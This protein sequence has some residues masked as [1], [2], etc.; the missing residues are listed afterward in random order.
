MQILRIHW[1]CGSGPEE[2]GG[3]WKDGALSVPARGKDTTTWSRGP[4]GSRGSADPPV[5]SDGLPCSAALGSLPALFV[6][7]GFL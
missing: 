6:P 7:F 2:T 5:S 1:E 3:N 4:R